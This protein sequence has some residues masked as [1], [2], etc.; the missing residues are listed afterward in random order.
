M[1]AHGPGGPRNLIPRGMLIIQLGSLKLRR[2]DVHGAAHGHSRDPS[3]E[4]TTSHVVL[5]IALGTI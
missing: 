2:P 4:Y 5:Y 3:L 1:V